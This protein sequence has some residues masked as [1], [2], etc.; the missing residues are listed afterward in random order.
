M[1]HKLFVMIPLMLMSRKLDGEDPDIIFILRCTYG[2][3]QTLL[4]L[5]IAY[6][7]H[8]VQK[9]VKSKWMQTSVIY[10][11][12]A[13]PP[14]PLPAADAKK[15]YT[16]TTFSTHL[17]TQAFSL[18][19]STGGGI[20]ITVALHMYRG[21]VMG[22]AMQSAMGPLNLH[23]NKLAKAILLN[24]CGEGDETS[25][26]KLRLF[27]EKYPSELTDEDE[28]VDDKGEVLTIK[29]IPIEE[30]IRSTWDDAV[31][32]DIAPLMKRLTREN[33]NTKTKDAGWTSIMIIG[34]LSVRGVDEALVTLKSL[35]AKPEI[36]DDDG[37]NAL[38]WAAF[39]GS[40]TSAK[41][42]MQEYS[43]KGLEDAK[44][45]DGKVPL[46]LAKTEENA[47]VVKIMQETSR[48]TQ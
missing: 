40:S 39:H 33:V 30:L 6:V 36:T 11:P 29:Q 23:D 26:M 9:A 19:K 47:G 3:V 37:W 12:I 38:H 45:K 24:Q 10:V 5:S 18:L 15:Q 7:F 48:K 42:L 13:I 16:K 8:K 22:L 21:M 14:F 27:D 4:M 35:G 44:D 34:C 1:S 17:Q 25:W 43:G 32:A 20:C 31:D 46:E 28:V 41:F 2:A